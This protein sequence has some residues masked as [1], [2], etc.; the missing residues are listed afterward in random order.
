[1]KKPFVFRLGEV[2]AV[3]GQET[4]VERKIE[5]SFWADRV[6]FSNVFEGGS[7]LLYRNDT[8]YSGQIYNEGDVV[9]IVVNNSSKN[10]EKVSVS[11]HGTIEEP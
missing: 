9:T 4:K 3:P 1:V 11:L 2:V 8:P 5:R 7:F 6:I 10:E